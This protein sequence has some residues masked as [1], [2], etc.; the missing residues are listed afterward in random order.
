MLVPTSTQ[1]CDKV[2]FT[3]HLVVVTIDEMSSCSSP[4]LHDSYERAGSS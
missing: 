3:M 2:A 1:I 4:Q